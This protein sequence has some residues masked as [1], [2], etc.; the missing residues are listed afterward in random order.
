MFL[1]FQNFEY[2][3]LK[4]LE[5]LVFPRKVIIFSEFHVDITDNRETRLSVIWPTDNREPLLSVSQFTN[6]HAPQVSVILFT[7]NREPLLSVI[8]VTDNH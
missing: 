1:D 4:Y 3:S 8:Q 7:D 6:N 5:F 2:I